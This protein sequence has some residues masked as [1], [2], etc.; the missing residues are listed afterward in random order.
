MNR[1]TNRTNMLEFRAA[2]TLAPSVI[3]NIRQLLS[4][5]SFSANPLQSILIT[6]LFANNKSLEQIRELSQSG[7]FVTFDSGGYYV[8]T[9][10]LTYHELYYPLLEAYSNNEWADVY[11]LPD[12]VPTT[13]DTYD[14]VWSKVKETVDFSKLFLEELPPEIRDRAMPV[15][16]GHTLEQVDYCLRA[17][18]DWGVKRLGFGSFGTFGKNSEV[19]IAT[20]S[21]VTLAQHVT[22]V[23]QT[24]DICVHLFGLGAPALVAKIFGIGADSFDS[25]SWIKAAGFGQIF[26]PFMRAYNITHHN[27]RS[28]LQQGITTDR[29]SELKELTGHQC[30]FCESVQKLQEEKVFRTVH[31]LIVIKETVDILN[32]GDLSRIKQ[33][34]ENGSP[35]YRQEYDRWLSR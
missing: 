28:E 5:H 34:Y 27:G 14:K 13:Q 30:P 7:A 32:S 9:G 17:Y 35:R 6:P 11:T 16:H 22:K 25:S 33:I 31:N 19:N 15:V 18:I 21:A 29:F 24:H 20:E 10:R 23:A 12:H 26:L 4:E 2:M 8:Q 3:H 1:R